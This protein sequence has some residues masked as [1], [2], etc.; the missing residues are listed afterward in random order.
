MILADWKP[1][2]AT[3]SK[4]GEASG[5][6]E[7][8]Q[9]VADDHQRPSVSLQQSPF[10]PEVLLSIGDTEFNLWRKDTQFPI[11]TSPSSL[12]SLTSGRWSPTRPSVILIGK[13][14]GSV[15]V[16]DMLDQSHQPSSSVS[17]APC[18]INSLEFWGNTSS[19]SQLLA[20]GDANGNLHIL[21]IPRTLWRAHAN[22]TSIMENSFFKRESDRLQYIKDK[23]DVLQKAET[24]DDH[25]NNNTKNEL[26]PN[27]ESP[28]FDQLIVGL[29]NPNE[30]FSALEHS[31][32]EEIGS[33]IEASGGF[34]AARPPTLS[35]DIKV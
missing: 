25:G 32:L 5:S 9:W 14:D 7:F 28:E 12:S 13:A 22:E 1:G 33:D 21:D 30:M 23:I 20:A 3:D 17:I 16:W 19:K 31:Y 4:S 15:D 2:N 18:S 26:S 27:S 24:V 10:Y 8:I 35:S 29:Q 6:L 11:F 34:Y